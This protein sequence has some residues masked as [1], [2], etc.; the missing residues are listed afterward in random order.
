MTVGNRILNVARIQ[1]VNKVMV[2]GLPLFILLCVFAVNLAL[3]LAVPFPEPEDGMAMTGAVISIY[4][5]TAIVHV[6]TMSQTLPFALGMSITRRDFVFAA[7]AVVVGQALLYGVVLWVMR[8]LERATG[9]W[10]VNVAMFDLAFMET[11]NPLTQIL[12]F[13]APFLFVSFCGLWAGIVFQRWGQLGVWVWILSFAA[14]LVGA[15]AVVGW[16]DWWSSVG[17]FFTDT[18]TVVLL[19]VYPTVIAVVFAA[20]TYATS[21]RAVG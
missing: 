3:F 16:Q 12:V 8:L 18:P 9:G 11:A 13:A 20:A 6:Q 5:A 4:I 7:G 21:R 1:L 2:I 15:T 10:G 17:S 19:G 14:V